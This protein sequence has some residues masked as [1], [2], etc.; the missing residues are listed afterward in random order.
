MSQLDLILEFGLG[1]LGIGLRPSGIE[2]GTTG[3]REIKMNAFN[4]S[5]NK[6]LLYGFD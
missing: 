1:E 5:A 3:F 2:P 6:P 4:F